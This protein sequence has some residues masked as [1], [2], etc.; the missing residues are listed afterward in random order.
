MTQTP[1]IE[2]FKQFQQSPAAPRIQQPNADLAGRMVRLIEH[3][4]RIDAICPENAG[5]LLHEINCLTDRISDLTAENN[6]LRALWDQSVPV[7][8]EADALRRENIKLKIRLECITASRD[9]LNR[10]NNA[11]DPAAIHAGCLKVVGGKD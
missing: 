5:W 11:T 3:L 6:R 4:D 2:L 10:I 9:M 8:N 1:T 7:I